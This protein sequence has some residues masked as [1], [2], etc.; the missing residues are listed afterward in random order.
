MGDHLHH[1]FL[2]LEF[3]GQQLGLVV[4]KDLVQSDQVR[5]EPLEVYGLALHLV[6]QRQVILV[7]FMLTSI[8]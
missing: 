8:A 2:L 4:N 5:S 7:F 1:N 6:E 3:F